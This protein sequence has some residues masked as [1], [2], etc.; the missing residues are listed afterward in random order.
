M[1][2]IASCGS[3]YGGYNGYS[4]DYQVVVG[5]DGQQY[6]VVQINGIQQMIL[7]S[8]FLNIYNQGGYNGIV[9]YYHTYPSYYRTYVPSS[10]Y[11]SAPRSSYQRAVYNR[12]NYNNKVNPRSEYRARTTR[13][14]VNPGSEFRS[15]SRDYGGSYNG[16]RSSS[17]VRTSTP[18]YNRSS[19][20][21]SGS[22][23][24]RS[25]SGSSRSSTTSSRRR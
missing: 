14:A 24:F 9:N 12:P 25:T 16:G 11:R 21:S 10:Y 22:S 3:G 23:S 4:D 7:Y 8:T 20:R 19:S 6:A 18:S 5:N 1:I 2:I 15:S 13:P 17:S